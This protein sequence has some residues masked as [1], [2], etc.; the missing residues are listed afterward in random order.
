MIN[1]ELLR[2]YCIGKDTYKDGVLSFL[3]KFH[4]EKLTLPMASLLKS[5]LT[6]IVDDPKNLKTI[7]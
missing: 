4:K 1:L 3:N 7:P 5:E 2:L 6:R